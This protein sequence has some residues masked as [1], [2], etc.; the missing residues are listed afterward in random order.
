MNDD[1]IEL[2]FEELE[3][4]IAPGTSLNDNEAMVGDTQYVAV[5][6]LRE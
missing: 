3:D 2:E 6:S 5:R 4:V 1:E